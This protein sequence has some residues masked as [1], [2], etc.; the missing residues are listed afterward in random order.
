MGNLFLLRFKSN[1]PVNRA[2]HFLPSMSVTCWWPQPTL[3]DIVWNWITIPEG[4]LWKKNPDVTVVPLFGIQ[5]PRQIGQNFPDLTIISH[6]KMA[7]FSFK[8]LG[9]F[10]TTG[11]SVRVPATRGVGLSMKIPVKT[12]QTPNGVEGHDV[13]R[14]PWSGGINELGFIPC[15]LLYRRNSFRLAIKMHGLVSYEKWLCNPYI[16]ARS[17]D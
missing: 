2:Y 5:L 9:T 10:K 15:C 16:H 7:T 11:A 3:R 1:G 13:K 6:K 12:H 14:W 4:F 17:T 8:C